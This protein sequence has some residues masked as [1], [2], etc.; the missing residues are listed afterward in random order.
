MVSKDVRANS[1]LLFVSVIPSELG[2]LDALDCVPLDD[3]KRDVCDEHLTRLA[4]ARSST[5]PDSRCDE[6][7]EPRNRRQ[8]V[9]RKQQPV[10]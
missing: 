6:A 10:R 9:K 8:A 5:D 7:N 3:T 2:L 1:T 4:R